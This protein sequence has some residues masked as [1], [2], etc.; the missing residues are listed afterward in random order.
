VQINSRYRQ[1]A[2]LVANQP[3][4]A[5]LYAQVIQGGAAP[6]QPAAAAA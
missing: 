5:K 2:I 3:T 4:G 1:R 6:A